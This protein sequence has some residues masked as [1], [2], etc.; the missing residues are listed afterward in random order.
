MNA[1]EILKKMTFEQKALVLTGTGPGTMETYSNAELGIKPKTF[2]DGPHGTRLEKE[3][4]CTS[5]PSLAAVGN[6]WSVAAAKKMGQA[7]ADECINNGIDMLLGPGTNIKRHILCGRNF[8][9]FSEDPTLAGELAAAYI[10]GLQE[11]G[12][13]ASLKHYAMNNQEQDRL[14]TSVETDERTM[15]EIYLK[16]FETAVK[17]A[18]PDSIMCAYNKINAIWCS[19]NEYLLRNIL[20]EEWNYDGMVVSDWG[21]VQN[22]SRAVK[23]GLDLQ[24]P[25]NPDI[26]AQ[27]RDGVEKGLVTEK[28]IDEAVLRM[29]EFLNKRQEKAHISYNRD[30]QHSIAREIA[31]E[32]MVLLKNKDE[33]LPLTSKKYKKIT[34]VGDY[35]ISPLIA[36]QGS[37][38]VLQS[39]AYT[40]SPLEELKKRLPDTEIAYINAYSKS[41]YPSEMIWP[42]WYGEWWHDVESA[43]AVIFFCG[44]MQSEDSEQFDRRSA[45]INPNQAYMINSAIRNGIKTIVVLQSGG[46]ILLEDWGAGAD[47]ILCTSLAGEGMGAA[48][49]DILCGK[50]NPSGKLAETFPRVIR[51]DL[52][53]PGDSYKVEYKERF[54]VG[55][56]YYDKH[57][58]EIFYPFG[59][60]ISYT[61]FAYSALHAEVDGENVNVSFNLKNTGKTDGAEVV[62]LYIGDPVSTV[63]KSIKELKRFEK[64]FLAAGEE[65]ELTFVLN[66]SDFSYYNVMLHE[67]VAENGAY[68]IYIGASSRDIRLKTRIIYETDM[69][70]TTRNINEAQIG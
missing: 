59:H 15:R 17:K 56:R 33:V 27:L 18:K 4:N 8:E 26:A 67:W 44:A 22:I 35:A 39:E 60:G 37:A 13:S 31:A 7:L 57:P 51:T 69:P 10:N 24:M 54:D 45:T 62:Q 25:P 28:E 21:A 58:E 43:D 38:E 30:L 12:V 63:V 64:V 29:L 70:Y 40:D 46:A 41:A 55:Y 5:F 50:I 66:K 34:V 6:S 52:D 47:A 19:E 11:K 48:V 14:I 36:G 2:A 65:K 16:P 32:S 9:Y 3:K 42:K 49:A 20:K 68:D 61:E 53:Y 23:A 1:K